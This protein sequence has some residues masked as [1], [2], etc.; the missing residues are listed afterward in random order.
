MWR[1]RIGPSA[2]LVLRSALYLVLG[3]AVIGLGAVD[4]LLYSFIGFAVLGIWLAANLV[5]PVP[6]WLARCHAAINWAILAV[7]AVS[8][9]QI[10]PGLP[11]GMLHPMF[12]E[13]LLG[14]GHLRAISANPS[15]TIS[16]CLAIIVALAAM[17]ASML[18]HQSEAAA[19]R[20]MRRSALVGG[21]VIG[22]AL[23]QFMVFPDTLLLFR[24]LAYRDSFTVTFVNRNTA[25][26][27]CGIVLL[28]ATVLALNDLALRR[29]EHSDRSLIV[30]GSSWS[31]WSMRLV[32]AVAA[33]GLALTR[34]RAGV[35]STLLPLL[36]VAALY[37][38]RFL[39]DRRLTLMLAGRSAFVILG[40]LALGVMIL[41]QVLGRFEI[42]GANSGRW[43]VY[44]TMVTAILE[45][46]WL[47]IGL[48]GFEVFY[49]TRRDPACGIYGEWEYLH[50][51]Y[52]EMLLSGGIVFSGLAL[53]F[54]VWL[55]RLFF[56]GYRR[57]RS[58]RV[59][60]LIGGA[61]LMLIACHSIFDFSIQIPGI[62]LL[63]AAI[64]GAAM[65]IASEI[66]R[67]RERSASVNNRLKS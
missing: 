59:V 40:V 8:A 23:V 67:R 7:L 46:P 32:V 61:I 9:I 44:G 35:V 62:G 5:L 20:F 45:R 10:L 18:L 4:R 22:L 34:S 28:L 36:A 42:Q 29:G 11:E 17:S 13:P 38:Y 15:A 33:I 58:F 54:I 56:A 12:S 21:L 25:A 65:P 1:K 37:G 60:P 63:V 19:M 50:S 64:L 30:A 43:C 31:E 55:A 47:G 53:V 52:L 49:P 2:D 41:D 14:E 27:F 66:P 3:L 57:R 24:K 6:A 51:V 39:H 16:T 48:G 26:T